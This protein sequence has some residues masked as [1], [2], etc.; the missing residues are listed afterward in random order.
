MLLTERI[1]SEESSTK[2]FEKRNNLKID[3]LNK[4]IHNTQI[5]RNKYTNKNDGLKTE[6][7]SKKGPKK[8]IFS[9]IK[10][11]ITDF[12][13]EEITLKH[14]Y[15]TARLSRNKKPGEKMLKESKTIQHIKKKYFPLLSKNNTLYYKNPKIKTQSEFNKYLI[16]DYKENIS[17]QDYI[18]RSLKYM[19]INDEFNEYHTLKKMEKVSKME[20]LIKAKQSKKSNLSDIHKFIISSKRNHTLFNSYYKLNRVI[21]RLYTDRSSKSKKNDDTSKNKEPSENNLSPKSPNKV[22]LDYCDKNKNNSTNLFLHNGLYNNLYKEKMKKY[23]KFLK[24]KINL[25]GK[26][27]SN[28]I[29]MMEIERGKYTQDLFDIEN[30]KKKLPKL[31]YNNLIYQIKL[32]N[33]VINSFKSMRLLSED[34]EDLGIDNPEKFKELRNENENNMFKILKQE[35]IPKC[36][37]VRFHKSTLEKYHSARGIH[38]GI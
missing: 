31:N 30:Q 32:K 1:N 26:N 2:K 4:Y 23:R 37:K 17:N 13:N 19:K 28:Q 27:F 34:D 15:M 21:K 22:I 7:C 10:Q 25:R 29:A 9:Q 24:D 3:V 12:E 16:N 18:K 38:L 36:I 5:K 35:D 8:K 20:K 14:M 11:L 33:I 6:R